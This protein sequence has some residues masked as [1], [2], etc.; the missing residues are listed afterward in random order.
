MAIMVMFLFC[1]LFFYVSA[2]IGAQED[3]GQFVDI[4][5]YSSRLSRPCDQDDPISFLKKERTFFNATIRVAQTES[6]S[7]ELI[8][9]ACTNLYLATEIVLKNHDTHIG[10]KCP[11]KGCLEKVSERC[12]SIIK[13]TE[14]HAIRSLPQCMAI[15]LTL[16]GVRRAE[17]RL[18]A[19]FYVRKEKQE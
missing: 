1:S 15:C 14:L 4:A 9:T 18:Y 10:V 8:R 6:N 17:W 13:N 2:F 7:D 3:Y 16:H 5:R 19:R 11:E 12:G